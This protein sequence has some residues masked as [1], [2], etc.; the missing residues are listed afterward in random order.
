MKYGEDRIEKAM[1][2]R[3]GT[4]GQMNEQDKPF[5]NRGGGTEKVL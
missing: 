2:L 3:K 5:Q 4:G 1:R